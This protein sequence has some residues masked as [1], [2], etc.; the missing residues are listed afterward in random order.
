MSQLGSQL[1]SRAP[2]VAGSAAGPP[3][4]HDDVISNVSVPVSRKSSSGVA[5]GAIGGATHGVEFA[6]EAAGVI[7]R[8]VGD[9]EKVRRLAL[10]DKYESVKLD[11]KMLAEAA[12][13]FRQAKIFNQLRLNEGMRRVELEERLKLVNVEEKIIMDERE[14][15]GMAAEKML[16]KAR[17]I[18]NKEAEA[19]RWLEQQ[20]F[21]SDKKFIVDAER[22]RLVKKRRAFEMSTPHH[23]PPHPSHPAPTGD[24]ILVM[25]VALGPSHDEVMTVREGDDYHQLASQ[26]AATHRLP[27]SVIEPLVDE[28]RRNVATKRT[29]RSPSGSSTYDH[30]HRTKR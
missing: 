14:R 17:R 20:K 5:N 24:I 25:T 15:L 30:L 23:H 8:L 6:E 27:P 1:G 9:K 2:S 28:I 10:G 13:D 29:S 18:F 26:F 4:A 16:R 19:A 22:D 11:D 3:P 7:N 21:E 12:E